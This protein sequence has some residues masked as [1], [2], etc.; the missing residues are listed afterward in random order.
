LT[1]LV[2]ETRPSTF[3]RVHH[4]TVLYWPL[5][6]YECGLVNEGRLL[7]FKLDLTTIPGNAELGWMSINVLH[8]T[9]S[10]SAAGC[11]EGAYRGHQGTGDG[12][13]TH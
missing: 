10:G 12:E 3:I 9:Y 4:S 6:Q 13:F 5:F 1:R 2:N 7:L 8:V 11:G